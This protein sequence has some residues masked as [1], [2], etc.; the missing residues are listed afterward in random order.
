MIQSGSYLN[1]VDN[2][3]A[4]KVKCI[5]VTGGYRKRYAQIGDTVVGSVKEIYIRK[6][7]KGKIKRGEVIRALVFRCKNFSSN[8]NGNAKKYLENS[9]VLINKQN[10]IVSTRIFGSG[11]SLFRKTKHLKV[12]SLCSGISI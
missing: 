5:Q 6:N 4:K 1:I 11:P 12:L 10:K 3:G 7:T 2:S 8:K 9:A